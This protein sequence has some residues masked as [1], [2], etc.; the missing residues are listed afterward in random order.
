VIVSGV[1]VVALLLTVFGAF[2]Y[3]TLQ[4]RLE[5]SL[6]EVLDARVELARELAA[7]HTVSRAPRTG[8]RPSASLRW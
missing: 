1:A 2:L 6:D 4:A 7:V 8:C 5:D 3:L